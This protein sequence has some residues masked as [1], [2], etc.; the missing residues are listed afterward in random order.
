MFGTAAHTLA[1]LLAAV[2]HNSN[3]PDEP[4][5][6]KNRDNIPAGRPEQ[7]TPDTTPPDAPTPHTADPTP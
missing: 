4:A 6:P 5:V 1:T 3:K 7:A 2:I